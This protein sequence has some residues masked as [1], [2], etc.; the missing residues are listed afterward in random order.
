M[1][2]TSGSILDEKLTLVPYPAYEPVGPVNQILGNGPSIANQYGELYVSGPQ[3]FVHTAAPPPSNAVKAGARIGGQEEASL[4]WW[5]IGFG[6]FDEYTSKLPWWFAPTQTLKVTTSSAKIVGKGVVEGAAK[7]KDGAK[8]VLW[9]VAFVL[10]ALFVGYF[11]LKALAVRGAAKV[12][13]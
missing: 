7:V 6:K 5:K 3:D 2:K 12:P 13:L 9:K 10:I 8:S 11:F 4:S 1:A